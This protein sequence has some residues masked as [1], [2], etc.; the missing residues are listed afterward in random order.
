MLVWAWA[1]QM[2]H[3]GTPQTQPSCTGEGHQTWGAV[4]PGAPTHCSRKEK[5]RLIVQPHPR[6]ESSHPL[7][8]LPASLPMPCQPWGLLTLLCPL[9]FLTTPRCVWKHF[10]QLT[11]NNLAVINV[12]VLVTIEKDT[13][14]GGTALYPA[15]AGSGHSPRHRCQPPALCLVW[16]HA[17]APAET[18][19]TGSA[20]IAVPRGP[21]AT[22]HPIPSTF[23]CGRHHIIPH[24]SLL[25][26][27][28]L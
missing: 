20:A 13:R 4:G 2:R 17:S 11:D 5:P 24:L 14:A 1:A 3:R 26:T 25:A 18:Q 21:A 19:G 23:K 7:P 6:M 12:M 16:L 10:A 22:P 9:G 8:P 27:F 28:Y 15:A